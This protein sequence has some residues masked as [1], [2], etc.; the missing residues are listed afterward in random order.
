MSVFTIFTD[1]FNR[2]NGA[3]GSNWTNLNGTF[4]VNANQAKP[5]TLGADSRA[6]SV[7]SGGVI[8]NDQYSQAALVNVA[9]YAGVVVRGALAAYTCYVAVANGT[10]SII[11]KFVAGTGTGLA[12]G[13]PAFAAGDVIRLEVK[14]TA[15]TLFK[16]GNVVLTATDSAIASGYA[17]I[18]GYSATNRAVDNWEGGEIA[19][20]SSTLLSYPLSFPASHKNLQKIRLTQMNTVGMSVSPFSLSQQLYDWQADAWMLDGSLPPLKMADA[21][22]WVAFLGGLRGRAGTFLGTDTSRKT[23]QGN[24]ASCV[25]V[26]DFNWTQNA[27]RSGILSLRGLVASRA[28]VLKAGDYIELE[29]NY[30]RQ[31]IVLNTLMPNWNTWGGATITTGVGGWP[32]LNLPAKAGDGVIGIY[33]DITP[34]NMV[35]AFRLMV[36]IRAVTATTTIELVVDDQPKSVTGLRS[37]PVPTTVDTVFTLSGSLPAT[38][39]NRIRV[40]IAA[41]TVGATTARAIEIYAVCL[42][43]PRV[44]CSLHKCL[45]DLN[46]DSS[47]NGSVDIFPRIRTQPG[48]LEPVYFTNY[49]GVFRLA[50]NKTQWDVDQAKIYGLSFSAM[51]AL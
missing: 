21:E 27:Q 51:E 11:Q 22:A 29:K 7:W 26:V 45:V 39:N 25:P 34:I 46:A 10:D 13:G 48:P 9:S 15:L 37:N 43:M 32:R 49:N 47:G 14:G 12:S 24:I 16:N 28:G 42:S 1:N 40:W 23:A 31:A 19:I 30:F 17:G 8:G 50:G 20:V 44:D 41:P 36:Y 18:A 5:L 6:Q 35:G 3:I 38:A 4:G 33:T 2:A